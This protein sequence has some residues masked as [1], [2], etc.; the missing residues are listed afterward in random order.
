M[1]PLAS[2]S[3]ARA[4][5]LSRDPIEEE[6]GIKLYG[7]VNNP[8][9]ARDPLG[10]NPALVVEDAVLLVEAA[11]VGA[12]AYQAYRIQQITRIAVTDFFGIIDLAKLA[13]L[14]F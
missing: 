14:R 6:G 4:R 5:W 1:N 2:R 9:N 8:I 3:G 7:Y 11:E 10:L 13:S 12:F